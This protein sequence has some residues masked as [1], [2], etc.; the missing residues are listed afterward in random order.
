MD[1]EEQEGF[2]LI[3]LLVVVAIIGVLASIAV[4]AFSDYKKRAFDTQASMLIRDG[5]V[6]ATSVLAQ[7]E[8]SL[9][10]AVLKSE[11]A[12]VI[13]PSFADEGAVWSINV[14]DNSGPNEKLALWAYHPKGQSGYCYKTDGVNSSPT[15]NKIYNLCQQE[16]ASGGANCRASLIENC[17]I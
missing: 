14:L 1:R 9:T 10:I 8:D 4:P 6:A 13:P 16:G 3:E 2:T 17:Q 5:L 11:M 15:L 7:T 12:K